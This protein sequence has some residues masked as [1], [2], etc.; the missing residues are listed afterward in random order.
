MCF[1]GHWLAFWTRGR[2]HIRSWHVGVWTGEGIHWQLWGKNSFPLRD[3]AAFCKSDARSSYSLII[4]MKESSW[5]L[6]WYIKGVWAKRLA[7]NSSWRLVIHLW[8]FWW[9]M[10][11]KPYCVHQF[12]LD[13]S[14]T[15]IINCPNWPRVWY[16]ERGATISKLQMWLGKEDMF[17][18]RAAKCLYPEL[19]SWWFW[20]SKN[21]YLFLFYS[22]IE[23]LCGGRYDIW[24][25]GGKYSGCCLPLAVFVKV[26][27]DSNLEGGS[28]FENGE[29]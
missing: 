16:Q 2:T 23:S 15:W 24:R 20:F 12:E 11:I 26:L 4:S 8:G 14:V 7:R 18:Q 22:G 3:G 6:N 17:T 27:R 5:R 19:G 28:P 21:G 29:G 25:S 9:H 10:L 1:V 13:F